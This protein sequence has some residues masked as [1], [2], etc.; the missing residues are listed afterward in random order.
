MLLQA[1]PII[2]LQKRPPQRRYC[3]G[4]LAALLLSREVVRQTDDVTEFKNGAVLEGA[5]ND[6]RL[7][8]GRSTIAVLGSE[9]R[10]WRP[11]K[12]RLR[13]TRKLLRAPSRA[14]RC[15]TTAGCSCLV[16]PFTASAATC[17]A[18]G[19]LHGSDDADDVCWL[20]P[21][22]VMDPVL[23]SKVIEEGVGRRP[24]APALNI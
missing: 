8:R 11:T 16:R 9:C 20:A 6:A 15:A 19:E 5:T 3:H 13:P 2:A 21:S 14:W 18:G 22:N 4:L 12:L 1:Q 23:P 17:T 7:I 24:G 10:Y